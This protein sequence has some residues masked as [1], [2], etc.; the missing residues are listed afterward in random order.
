VIRTNRLVGQVAVVKLLAAK[1]K[2]TPPHTRLS[3]MVT[4]KPYLHRLKQLDVPGLDV[5][6][7]PHPRQT[8]LADHKTTNYLYYFLAGKWAKASGY[9]EAIILNP[10]GSISETNSANLIIIEGNTAVT[11]TSKSVLPGVMLAQVLRWF[12]KNGY[13]LKARKLIPEDLLSADAVW[14][15]NSLIG[16]VP[17]LSIDGQSVKGISLW[18]QINT[19][20]L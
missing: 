4:A 18:E 7:Y 6:V 13:F 17:V 1:G 14:L 16:T 10:D 3:V 15:T 20:L 2:E 19:E 8:P 11:P 12:E 9:H 5:G